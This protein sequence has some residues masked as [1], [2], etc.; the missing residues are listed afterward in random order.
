MWL[1][2]M[3]SVF[4]Y[5]DR[6]LNITSQIMDQL[7]GDERV[8]RGFRVKFPED[9]LQDNLA[10]QLW[11]GAEVKIFTPIHTIRSHFSFFWRMFF[12]FFSQT[13][14]SISIS[15]HLRT[16]CTN[17]TRL[18][19]NLSRGTQFKKIL[20]L[21]KTEPDYSEVNFTDFCT[22]RAFGISLQTLI[23]LSFKQYDHVFQCLAAGSSIMNREEESAA[24]RPLAK[25]LTRSLETVRSLLREQC[26]RPRGM[27]LSQHDDMLHESLRIFDR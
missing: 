7:L 20:P 17:L 21:L 2:F 22:A 3:K 19:S 11:F 16:V 9:V 27:A 23:F 15:G 14:Q 12:L 24:M 10:G 26:L 4:V 8:A 25:A 6:V 5:Q 13:S 18:S 1:Y